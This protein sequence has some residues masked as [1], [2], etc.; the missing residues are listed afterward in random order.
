MLLLAEEGLARVLRGMSILNWW[1]GFSAGALII[2][3]IGLV[4][5]LV[6]PLIVGAERQ[7]ADAAHKL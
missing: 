6:M 4:A 3:L 2:N 5:M 7:I 1:A